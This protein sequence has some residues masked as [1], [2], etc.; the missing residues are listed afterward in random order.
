VLDDATEVGEPASTAR[1]PSV[2]E[3]LASGGSTHER[4][5]ATLE[6]GV[7]VGRYLVLGRV[8]R[9]GMGEV[10]AAHDPELDR[11][12]ALKLLHVRPGLADDSQAR[13]RMAR[14][15]QAMAR[16]NHPNTVTVH[17]V[18]EHEG[19]VFLAMEFVEGQTL[20][21]W[22]KQSPRGWREVVTVFMAAGRGLAAAHA[23]GLIHRDFKP[24]N[25]MLTATGRVLVMDFGLAR[26]GTSESID[27]APRE[28]A[29]GSDLE[30]TALA[31]ELDT[32]DSLSSRSRPQLSTSL[33]QAGALLGTPAYMAP[34]QL[35]GGNVDA[36]S[37]QWAFCVTFWEALHGQ[38]PFP[39]KT[40][41][42]LIG[43][44]LD[45]GPPPS[46]R[47][48]GVPT[49]LHRLVLRGLARKPEQRWPSLDVLL[50]ELELLP[51]RR[52][53]RATTIVGGL[54][55][56]SMIA[57]LVTREDEVGD[58]PCRGGIALIEQDWDDAARAEVRAEL[59]A[60]EQPYAADTWRVVEAELD[61]WG[62]RW[63]DAHRDT[64]EATELR[65]E[66]SDERLDARMQCLSERRR[67]F[68]ALIGNLRRH[69]HESA[70]VEDAALRVQALP[71]IDRCS[72]PAY[73]QARIPA[74]EEP[75][76]AAEVERTRERLI[77]LHSKPRLSADELAEIEALRERALVIEYPP[78]LAELDCELGERLFDSGRYTDAI[79]RFRAG[80][81]GARRI[82]DEPRAITCG[83]KLVGVL[84][85]N[86]GRP[87]DA[88]AFAE[89]VEP[90]IARL[91]SADD[92]AELDN[93]IGLAQHSAGD[94]VAAERS[95][96]RALEQRQASGDEL[97]IAN[98]QLN[99]GRSLR[100]RGQ[101]DAARSE[102]ERAL[103]GMSGVLGRAHP[104]LALVLDQLGLL[105]SQVGDL[106]LAERHF[107]S[108]LALREAALG[109]E[110]VDLAFSHNNLGRVQIQRGEYA[111]GLRN[112][113]AALAIWQ[114]ESGPE[115]ADVARG[116]SNVGV[117]LRKLGRYDEAREH[118]ERA[119]AIYELALGP[120][121][122]DFAIALHN[123]GNLLV[124]IDD[125]EPARELQTRALA[126][127]TR[128]FG[129]EHVLIAHG[130]IGLALALHRLG[131][132]SKAIAAAERGLEV[133]A[134]SGST[135]VDLELS[136]TV[137]L[138]QAELALGRREQALA[139]ANRAI[140]RV[141]DQP[142][143]FDVTLQRAR[144]RVVLAELLPA[145]RQEL[146]DAARIDYAALPGP[147]L[148]EVASP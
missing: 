93:G 101:W 99:L 144:V 20:G 106:E 66:Q 39:G 16:L 134:G 30:A 72:D 27:A 60:S 5:P 31:E 67:S 35:R 94:Y 83:I 9:G 97:V 139:H 43:A 108:A 40:M 69:G 138:A 121:H 15:A 81:F 49:W 142:E 76:Q 145:R 28:L 102:L 55:L 73:L 64:C 41:A 36:R 23:A 12:V 147:P 4:E 42:Q 26:A 86:A 53:R 112:F 143:S 136:G 111:D 115:H 1:A 79:E 118:Y 113:E 52:R 85:N 8:G 119:M 129:A 2:R 125:P 80:Y 91:G 56:A 126:I 70:V 89:H 104:R 137:V 120:E 61:D 98:T 130:S 146:L 32:A 107:Q 47:R 127:W 75:E 38:R 19:R 110:H 29:P 3:Q 87:A 141:A 140:A 148:P 109:P 95:F 133:L 90:D 37:D 14:E 45:G 25:V 58:P 77:E 68:A 114:R 128:K 88:L 48:S 71:D 17:D 78:L 105:E 59:L 82:A 7:Q 65:H 54:A 6:R 63:A 62:R 124:L 22:L 116:H 131:E 50:T 92:R 103:E 11:K 123:L 96:T 34:E 24:D 100:T 122:D 57:L 44:V 46:P 132:P 13:A 74:P 117:A 51:R 135:D 18:G 33:T 10:F 84:G 21:G